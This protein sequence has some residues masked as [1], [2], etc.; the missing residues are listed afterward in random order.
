M[1]VERVRCLME[2][3]KT[4]GDHDAA[5]VLEHLAEAMELHIT[6]SL[7]C[8]VALEA[9]TREEEM[10]A[11]MLSMVC[12]E[13]QERTTE[14]DGSEWLGLDVYFD[15][16]VA[17]Y[18]IQAHLEDEGYR[19]DLR[20]WSGRRGSLIFSATCRTGRAIDWSTGSSTDLER[21]LHD[22]RRRAVQ[23]AA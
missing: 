12:E 15:L 5:L 6:A 10:F 16:R 9:P 18:H 2:Q 23:H 1:S 3:L 20:C 21:V 22:L 17:H 4:E 14:A 8:A 13:G 7:A 11:A 19:C